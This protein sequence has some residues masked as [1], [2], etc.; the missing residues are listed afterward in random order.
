MTYQPVG[1]KLNS[2]TITRF[3]ARI[4]DDFRRKAGDSTTKGHLNMRRKTIAEKKLQGTYQ[5]Y[6]DDKK[7]LDFASANGVDIKPPAFIR[8]NKIASAE[9]KNLIPH[10]L[11]E[12]IL[13][14][15]DLSLLANFCMTYAHWRAAVED[16]EKQGATILVTSQTRTGSCTKPISNPAVRHEVLYSAALVKIGAKL[17]LSPLDR[18]RIPVPENDETGPDD[19][20]QRFLDQGND[21]PELDYIFKPQSN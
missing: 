16:V 3:L 14:Q 2:S 20:F 17:G 4:N 1:I 19:P 6:R 13:R 15:T 8:Q 5:P 12:R 10:L 7:R 18:D 21:D 11:A 9:Y